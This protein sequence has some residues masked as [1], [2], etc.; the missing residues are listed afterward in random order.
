MEL[1]TFMLQLV[2]IFDA[3]DFYSAHVIH[4]EGG[5]QTPQGSNLTLRTAPD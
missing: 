2:T 1:Q 4:M 5:P 3:N